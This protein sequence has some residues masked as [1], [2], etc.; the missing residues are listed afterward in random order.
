LKISIHPVIQ[1]L[2]SAI[3]ILIPFFY[4]GAPLYYPDS[5][6]YLFWGMQGLPPPER[7]GTYCMV[8]KGLSFGNSL[9]LVPVFQGLLVA[10]F[11]RFLF[12]RIFNIDKPVYLYFSSAVLGLGSSLGWTTAMLM[13]DIFCALSSLSLIILLLWR[14]R[15]HFTERVL[16]ILLFIASSLQHVSIF[17]INVLIIIGF[18]L[19]FLFTGES[20][21]HWL[22]LLTMTTL[23][24][25]SY[26][27]IGLIHKSMTGRF[28]I[29]QSS[30]AFLMGRLIETG[31]L[32]NYL[33]QTCSVE[34]NPLCKY[35]GRLPMSCEHFMWNKE[36]FLNETGGLNDRQMLYG[37]T[38]QKIFSKPKFIFLFAQAGMKSMLKQCL[39]VKVGDGLGR[40]KSN[41]PQLKFYVSDLSDYHM[42]R[43]KAGIDFD[44]VNN[45]LFAVMG[46]LLF[47][48][49][50][51]YSS[52]H[53]SGEIRMFGIGLILLFLANALVNGAL[54]TPLNR[55]QARV[56][57]LADVWLLA[58]LFPVLKSY[59]SFESKS[60]Q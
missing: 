22:N 36:S 44:W 35:R 41:V 53:I 23:I 15:L 51:N 59:F 13:P 3:L 2:I 47:L 11:L 43:Q 24:V 42:S 52:L 17:F 58:A 56:F 50:R 19:Y 14:Q 37:Q 1:I 6:G 30:N 27:G 4:N 34:Q 57:W 32:S 8:I 25:L 49:F 46:I 21:R 20:K 39:L 18:T 54:A 55:Y 26:V 5:M 45:L 48:L 38:I 12:V 16:V 40:T 28:F 10:G 7:A 33:D 9:W 29:S 31:I 60:P